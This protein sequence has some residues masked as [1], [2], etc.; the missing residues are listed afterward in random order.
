MTTQGYLTIGTGIFWGAGISVTATHFDHRNPWFYVGLTVCIMGVTALNTGFIL[1]RS[2]SLRD[3][4]DAGYR[5]GYREGRR[6]A[7]LVA[8][9][10]R[11]DGGLPQASVRSLASQR[12]A[13]RRAPTYTH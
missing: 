9:N 12:Q 3:E 1:C 5:T 6:R 7:P 11:N 4:F 8:V 2:R 10:R 13:S